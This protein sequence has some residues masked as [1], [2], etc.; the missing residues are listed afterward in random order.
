LNPQA[1]QQG[2][3]AGRPLRQAPAAPAAARGGWGVNHPV[4]PWASCQGAAPPTHSASCKGQEAAAK[5]GQRGTHRPRCQRRWRRRGRCCRP[6]PGSRRGRPPARSLPRGRPRRSPAR[7]GGGGGW[8]WGER[9]GGERG[10][11][12]EGLVRLGLVRL[13]PVS[14]T[15]QAC[16]LASGRCRTPQLRQSP[17][18]KR[19]C[20]RGRSPRRAALQPPTDFRQQATR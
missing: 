3:G 2:H 1:G 15:W 16:M 18:P 6:A 11:G 8:V 4:A 14:E 19:L 10:R 13:T 20:S 9:G 17:A 5:G 7:R 12:E